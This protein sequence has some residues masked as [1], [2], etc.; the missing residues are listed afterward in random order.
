M[1]ME[2]P[3][4][5]QVKPH[6]SDEKENAVGQPGRGEWRQTCR[7]DQDIA[8]DVQ[9]IVDDNDE[10]TDC[11]SADSTGSFRCDADGDAEQT[12]Y[13]RGRRKGQILIIFRQSPERDRVVPLSLCEL[14]NNGI[15]RRTFLR[16]RVPAL[17]EGEFQIVTGEGHVLVLVSLIWSGV[18]DSVLQV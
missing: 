4:T 13:Q 2:L 14:G 3:S 11:K 17:A 15:V 12:K 5:H 18:N 10:H 9:Y 6:D 7:R 1:D 8:R 16:S